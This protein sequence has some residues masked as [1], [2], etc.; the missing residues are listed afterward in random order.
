M[1][2]VSLSTRV[3]LICAGWLPQD[4]TFE[5][6]GGRLSRV[7]RNHI[8]SQWDCSIVRT[9]IPPSRPPTPSRVLIWTF[10]AG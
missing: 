8:A 3:S 1:S 6:E 5:S 10:V 9:R 2:G 4:G 7:E